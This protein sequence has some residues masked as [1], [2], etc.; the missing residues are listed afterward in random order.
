MPETG[1]QSMIFSAQILPSSIFVLPLFFDCRNDQIDLCVV[2]AFDVPPFVFR[3]VFLDLPWNLLSPKSFPR[4]GFHRMGRAL[5]PFFLYNR[6]CSA[7]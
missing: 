7:G 6:C 5:C 3:F 4:S 2:G 1:L